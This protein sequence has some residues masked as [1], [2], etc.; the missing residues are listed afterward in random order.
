MLVAKGFTQTYDIDFTKAF[1]SVAKLNTIR[2]LLSL[3]VNMDWPLLQR[4]VK[5]AF[6]HGDLE[7]EVYMDIP[8]GYMPSSRNKMV[9][10]LERAYMD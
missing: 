1:S 8:L 3:T 7:E 10:K 9:C 5:N 6:L 2:V 4:D